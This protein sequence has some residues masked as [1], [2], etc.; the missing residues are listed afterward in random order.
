[1][2]RRAAKS[3]ELTA[4][5]IVDLACR[6]AESGL[7]T[8]VVAGAVAFAMGNG[9]EMPPEYD[10][11][12]T[13]R[14][15]AIAFATFHEEFERERAEAEGRFIAAWQDGDSDALA[16]AVREAAIA[17][18][19]SQHLGAFRMTGTLVHGGFGSQGRRDEPVQSRA[20]SEIDWAVIARA[21]WIVSRDDDTQPAVVVEIAGSWATQSDE[22]RQL[23][24][25]V[26]PS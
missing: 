24:R 21:C 14:L 8:S 10:L 20:V 4:E 7:P 15:N 9:G 5:L 23:A 2:V 26:L 1:M 13:Q 19:A 22:L 6:A 16:F 12:M 25:S 18:A 11:W 3:V 17:R